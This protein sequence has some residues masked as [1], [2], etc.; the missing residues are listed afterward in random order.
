MLARHEKLF[1]YI[2]AIAT[3]L[4]LVGLA[5]WYFFISSK[6]NQIENTDIA[7]GFAIGVPSFSGSRGSTSENIA[8]SAEEPKPDEVQRPPR[9]WRVSSSPVAGAGFTTEGKLRYVERSTGYVFD[10]NPET[11]EVTRRTNRLMPKVYEADVGKEHAVL[12]RSINED[13]AVITFIGELGTSTTDGF[14]DLEGGTLD[15]PLSDITLDDDSIVFLTDTGSKVHLIRAAYDGTDPEELLSLN[16]GS[17]LI[18]N[19]PNRLILVERAASGVTGSAYEAGR[20]NLTPLVRNVRGLTLRAHGSSTAILIGREESTL[21]LSLRPS[22]DATSVELPIRTTADKCVF[23]PG[24][25]LIAYCAVPDEVPPEFMTRYAQGLV[26]TTDAWHKVSLAG[27]EKFYMM[28]DAVDVENPLVDDS[29]AY[30]TFQNARDK[31]L[32]LL[33]IV[34]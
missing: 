19:N 31:S 18:H 24:V 32:W 33:R 28:E 13:N 11:G 23:A 3:S 21:M 8:G 5:G 10:A 4:L 1:T 25:E 22:T 16:V 30:M 29:G 27:T 26:H 20:N 2:G 34:E 7:R 6:T 15:I 17:F 9:L 14:V 12:L